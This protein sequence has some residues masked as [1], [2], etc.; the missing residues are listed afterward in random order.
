MVSIL[1]TSKLNFSKFAESVSEAFNL[2]LIKYP[3]KEKKL[4]IDVLKKNVVYLIPISEQS[5]EFDSLFGFGEKVIEISD[6]SILIDSLNSDYVWNEY[7]HKVIDEYINLKLLSEKYELP[8]FYDKN[9][10]T[11]EEVYELI[12]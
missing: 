11:K 4:S 3:F 8:F 1:C 12:K 6:I 7:T 9:N 5:N 10:L 2:P